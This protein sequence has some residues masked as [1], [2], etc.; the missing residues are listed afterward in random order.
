MIRLITFK[1]PAGEMTIDFA[2]FLKTHRYGKTYVKKLLKLSNAENRADMLDV[3]NG[4]MNETKTEYKKVMD[5][6]Q[7][8]IDAVD[9][10]ALTAAENEALKNNI[11]AERDKK[12][13]K[14][15]AV[16]EKMTVLKGVI[17]DVKV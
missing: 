2:A 4:L 1:Y 7:A 15:N 10:M 8:E 14:L 11:R 3:L 16:Y 5:D 6:A 13:K 12:R 17:Q 9:N